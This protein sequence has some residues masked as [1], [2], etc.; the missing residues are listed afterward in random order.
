MSARPMVKM[1]GKGNAPQS[2]TLNRAVPF[3]QTL[4][5][6]GNP[7]PS[8]NAVYRQINMGHTDRDDIESEVT[9]GLRIEA[10]SARS[11]C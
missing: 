3:G 10:M 1:T 7:L 5:F 2:Q 11:P 9:Q 8:G 6:S 4:L